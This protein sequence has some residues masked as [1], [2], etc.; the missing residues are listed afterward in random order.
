MENSEIVRRFL[1]SR[2]H[3]KQITIL[4]QIALRTEEEIR[5]ILRENK[6]DPDAIPP[7]LPKITTEAV[8]YETMLPAEIRKEVFD[9]AYY[10]RPKRR[11]QRF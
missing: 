8:G 1:W 9:D 2:D 3:R 7:P 10:R 11:T 4:S 5:E 6:V